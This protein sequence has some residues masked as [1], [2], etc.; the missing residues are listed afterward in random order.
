MNVSGWLK[1]RIAVIFDREKNCSMVD[2]VS[3]SAKTEA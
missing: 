2:E 3:A 1:R